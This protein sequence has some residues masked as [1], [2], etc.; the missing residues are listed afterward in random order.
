MGIDYRNRPE[1]HDFLLKSKRLVFQSSIYHSA[2]PANKK[3]AS[4]IPG[5]VYIR[6]EGKTAEVDAIESLTWSTPD[7]DNSGN[8]VFGLL[9]DLGDNKARKVYSV[10]MSLLSPLSTAIPTNLGSASTYAVLAGSTITNT[11]LSVITGDIGV[12]PGTAI[13]GFPPGTVTGTQHSNDAAAAQAQLDVTVAYNDLA[14]RPMTSDLSGQNLGGLTLLPG[15]YRFSSSAQL[16]GTLVLDAAGDANATWVFQIGSTLTTASSAVVSIINS[17][18]AAN[19]FWQVG[20]SATLGTSTTFRGTILAL[21]SITANTSAS[22]Q[23]RAL[24]RNGAVTL[25]TNAVTVTASPSSVS[26]SI[27]GPNSVAN[28]YLTPAGNIAVE[29]HASALN[30]SLVDATFLLE[31]EFMSKR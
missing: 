14:A 18:S 25:D 20:S 10:L 5:A 16:T 19:V 6:S 9:I 26:L 22:I 4:E 31:V 13:V 17:G 29:V 12:S 24:A 28:A 30:L 3:H 23:G 2:T 27:T 15:V 21:A 8:S 1:L 11:G 7:D